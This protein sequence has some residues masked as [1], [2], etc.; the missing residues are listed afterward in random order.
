M[1]K[2][3]VTMKLELSPQE[4]FYLERFATENSMKY[5]TTVKHT[6]ITGELLD[7]IVATGEYSMI[8]FCKLLVEYKVDAI[9]D[10]LIYDLALPVI[11][12]EI[13]KDRL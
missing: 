10:L 13:L 5:K 9:E 12:Q 1:I 4:L 11:I 8:E 2:M 3:K 6:L 7:A